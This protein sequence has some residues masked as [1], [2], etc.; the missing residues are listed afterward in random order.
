M[1]HPVNQFRSLMPNI[2][3]YIVKNYFSKLN[4]L[5]NFDVGLIQVGSGVL[6]VGVPSMS[7]GVVVYAM[8]M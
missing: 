3:T 1:L 8:D 7:F 4:V 2:C 5:S 6:D